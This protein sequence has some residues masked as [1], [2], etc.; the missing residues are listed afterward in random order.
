M[1]SS[2]GWVICH[3]S[4][5]WVEFGV[6]RK[7]DPKGGGF[8]KPDRRALEPPFRTRYQVLESRLAMFDE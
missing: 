3:S 4:A 8:G 7:V 5:L 1:L 2:A 6:D